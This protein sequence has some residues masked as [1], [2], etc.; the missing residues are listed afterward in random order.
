MSGSVLFLHGRVADFALVAAADERA[1]DE[2]V[3]ALP[4]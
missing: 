4:K 3:I 2:D 1:F